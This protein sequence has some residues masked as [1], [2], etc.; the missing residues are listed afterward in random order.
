MVEPVLMP[1][2]QKEMMPKAKLIQGADLSLSIFLISLGIFGLKVAGDSEKWRQ[3]IDEPDDRIPVGKVESVSGEARFRRAYQAV[4][5]DVSKPRSAA[6]GDVIF[7]DDKSEAVLK[8]RSRNMIRI[9]PGSLVV[10]RIDERPA[11]QAK[12]VW[13]DRFFK[14]VEEAIDSRASIEV[15]KGAIEVLPGSGAMTLHLRH[16]GERY[17]LEWKGEKGTVQV[18]ANGKRGLEFAATGGAEVG[19]K[20][21]GDM[22][23]RELKSGEGLKGIQW[24]P[25]PINHAVEV[26]VTEAPLNGMTF[27]TV[28]GQPSE[29]AFRWK[30][31][32]KG[33]STEIEI[34]GMGDQSEFEL[35]LEAG[36]SG[37]ITALY[38][39]QYRW[40]VHSK[41]AAGQ[42]SDWSPYG[43][44]TMTV[45]EGDPQPLVIKG[46]QG[47]KMV[48]K[49]APVALAPVAEKP[50]KAG[51][52]L[53][54]TP[55]L[56]EPPKGA[57][58][59]TMERVIFSWQRVN[60]AKQFELELAKSKTFAEKALSVRVR[61][62]FFLHRP[63]S[64]GLLYWRVRAFNDHGAGKW[65]EIRSIEVK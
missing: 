40:R 58:A 41:N 30:P 15:K 53:P 17:D 51:P 4:W 14:P 62:N 35:K 47:E 50:T 55:V 59:A 56:T 43:E 7:T 20:G 9:A 52:T 34:N 31:L 5:E 18:G 46:A 61:E 48:L 57:K 8:L 64:E 22:T 19:V 23:A 24:N 28:P 32:P 1:E 26:P 29:V 27:K 60:G 36:R 38:A 37:T 6:N 13:W 65:S 3:M 12:D 45:K 42:V 39:G 10:V 2:K 33:L 25:K 16:E 54:G 49:Q 63:S 11:G 44:I 21:P